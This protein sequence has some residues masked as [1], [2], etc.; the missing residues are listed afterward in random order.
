MV[1][2]GSIHSI[3]AIRAM[4]VVISRRNTVERRVSAS[5]MKA[6]SV[7]KRWVSAA[8]LSRPIWARSASIMWP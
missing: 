5:R 1:R 3:A 4:I 7:V 2:T 8:G 6:K